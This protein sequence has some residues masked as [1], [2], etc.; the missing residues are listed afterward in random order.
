MVCNVSRGPRC[1]NIL[2]SQKKKY[3]SSGFCLYILCMRDTVHLMMK[4]I[5]SEE[6][7][8]VFKNALF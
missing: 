8:K 1:L 6:Q 2:C 7:S 4:S 5:L 3:V